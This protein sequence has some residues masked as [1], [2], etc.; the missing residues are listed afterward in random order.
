NTKTILGR[1]RSFELRPP[2]DLRV[3]RSFSKLP[4][5]TSERMFDPLRQIYR[6]P[7]SYIR[8]IFRGIGF[9]SWNPP[10]P[11]P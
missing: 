1:L 5:H 4:H 11:K 2:D 8:R 10:T 7:G 6:A 3:A 9:R